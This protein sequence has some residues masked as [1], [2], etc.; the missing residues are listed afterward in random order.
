MSRRTRSNGEGEGGDALAFAIAGAFAGVILLPA[1]ALLDLKRAAAGLAAGLACLGLAAA[2]ATDRRSSPGRWLAAL[3]AA[4]RWALVAVA[5]YALAQRLGLEPL[6]A[7][8]AAG[9]ATRAMGSFGNASYLAAFLCLSWPLLL[10]WRG[11]R[12]AVGLGLVWAALFATQSRSGLLAWALQLGLWAWRAWR[13]GWRPR[14]VAWGAAVLVPVLLLLLSPPQGW[15]RPTARWALWRAAAGLWWQRPWCGWYTVPFAIAFQR[16][17]APALVQVVNS[18]GQYAEDPHQLLLAVA[19]RVGAVGL[20]AFA[21]AVAWALRLAWR[22]RSDELAGAWLGLAGLLAESQADRFFFQAG[23]LA[24]TLGLVA[25]LAWRQEA[26]IWARARLGPWRIPSTLLAL[27]LGG[28]CLSGALWPL[29]DYGRAVGPGLGAGAQAIAPAVGLD[30]LQ[31]AAV[32][33]HDPVAF[34]RLGAALAARQRYAEA[35]AAYRQALRLGPTTGRA[36]NLGNCSMMLGDARGA[37]GAFRLAVALDPGS[38]DAHFSL[39]YALFYQKRLK[40]AV[41]ELDKALALD[42]GNASARTL[43]AQILP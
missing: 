1:T 43:K 24:P 32:G 37:E 3:L 38:S 4:W 7:Y 14:Q 17:G 11:S 23:V 28:A 33:S 26:W 10:A 39:G 22:T 27:V 41:A 30:P 5:G 25:A 34:E 6:A 19:C 21:V 35:A 16:H 9:S 12:R 42:P 8:A 13:G 36:Q 18:A 15:A 40:A 2:L 29:V 31:A 20:V